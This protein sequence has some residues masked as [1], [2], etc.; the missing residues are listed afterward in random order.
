[1]PLFGRLNEEEGR[2]LMHKIKNR[3]ADE[4]LIA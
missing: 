4:K 1:M 3:S 2:I